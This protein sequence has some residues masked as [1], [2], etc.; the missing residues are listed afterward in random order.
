METTSKLFLYVS[1]GQLYL[2]PLGDIFG[3]F[4][5]G[6]IRWSIKFFVFD[7]GYVTFLQDTDSV[8]IFFQQWY[9]AMGQF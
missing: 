1:K 7:R 4:F 5:L 9:F 2:K 6:S 3:D 8:I